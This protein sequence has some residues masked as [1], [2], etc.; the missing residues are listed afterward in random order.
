LKTRGYFKLNSS[1]AAELA[2]V[3]TVSKE[4]AA[5]LSVGSLIH[6]VGEQIR[7]VFKADITYVALLDESSNMISFPYTYG[8]EQ[9][10]IHYGEGL[11]GKIIQQ[12]S[13]C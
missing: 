10:P 11:T 8:E 6:L 5:E 12:G 9:S 3:H 4:L 7:A 1:G 13:R 2:T